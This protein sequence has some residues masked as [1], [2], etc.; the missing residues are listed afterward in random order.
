MQTKES[1]Q[2]TAEQLDQ[3]KN[4]LANTQL[5]LEKERD[6]HRLTRGNFEDKVNQ[7]Q[8]DLSA[9][10]SKLKQTERNLQVW[11]MLQIS[12]NAVSDLVL[13]LCCKIQYANI[14]VMHKQRK[15]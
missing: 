15:Q 8:S 9:T 6:S 1:L 3:T 11:D 10:N 14:V 4:Q 12:M 2:A 7:L 13:G 5:D